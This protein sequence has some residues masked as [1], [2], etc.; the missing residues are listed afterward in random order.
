[1]TL[2][3]T[4]IDTNMPYESLLQHP[5]AKISRARTVRF[6]PKTKNHFAQ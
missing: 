1:M 2:S 4:E 3:E 5:K 6:D